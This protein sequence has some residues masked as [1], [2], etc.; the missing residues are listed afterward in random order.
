MRFLLELPFYHT[1]QFDRMLVAQAQAE[2]L[3]LRL[4]F[5]RIHFPGFSV[6]HKEGARRAQRTLC[7]CPVRLGFNTERPSTGRWEATGSSAPRLPVGIVALSGWLSENKGTRREC[8]G[9]TR[10][11]RCRLDVNG[12]ISSLGLT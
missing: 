2:S 11:A 1:D 8:D 5:A 9:K 3:K 12:Q 10:E 7:T 6:S 4:P